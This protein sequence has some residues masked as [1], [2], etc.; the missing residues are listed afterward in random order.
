MFIGICGSICAGKHTIARYLVDH[1][2]FTQLHLHLRPDQGA[3]QISDDETPAR[4]R[5][6][7]NRSTIRPTQ[8]YQMS[9]PYHFS[10]PDDL[11]DFVTKHWRGRWVTTDVP[12]E[13]VLDQYA[14]RPFFLLISVDAPVTVRWQ[15]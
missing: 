13:S 9:Q 8:T 7:D 6:N 1:H 11:L 2:G 10:R 12:S 4:Y 14:R 15:R 5:G 3:Q